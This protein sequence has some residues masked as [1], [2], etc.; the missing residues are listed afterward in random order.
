M[1]APLPQDGR[2]PEHEVHIEDGRF[3]HAVC[4]CGWRTA[5]RRDRRIVRSEARDHALLYAG[6]ATVVEPA[7]EPAVDSR[8]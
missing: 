8:S 4:T 3:S 7:A 6:R 2:L 1:T 5:A